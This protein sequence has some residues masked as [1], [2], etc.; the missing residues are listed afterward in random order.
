[1]PVPFKKTIVD[2]S[3]L[4][5]DAD[6]FE[7]SIVRQIL[8]TLAIGKTYESKDAADALA[9][10]NHRRP[11]ALVVGLSQKNTD[12]L[13]FVRQVRAEDQSECRDIPLL[14]LMHAPTAAEILEARDAGVTEIAVRPIAADIFEKRLRTMIFQPRP[15]IE[16]EVYV[17]P[18]RRRKKEEAN[19]TD[20]RRRS[21]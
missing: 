13:H 16:A 5:F 21:S 8:R 2:Q 4:V 1:M 14:A 7:L 10:L 20:E 9:I 17:G 15:F 3:V 6:E 19:L 18:D 12:G 11:D